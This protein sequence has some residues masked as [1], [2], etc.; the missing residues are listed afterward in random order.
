M[1]AGLIYSGL[2]ASPL[3]RN[4]RLVGRALSRARSI[5]GGLPVKPGQFSAGFQ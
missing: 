5:F 4:P 2:E 1:I 3:T